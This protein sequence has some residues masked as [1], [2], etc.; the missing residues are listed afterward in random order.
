[1]HTRMRTSTD[2]NL[3]PNLFQDLFH[4]LFQDLF[5]NLFPHLFR[6]LFRC[7]SIILKKFLKT[8]HNNL[9]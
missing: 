7:F 9:H 8:V 4:H 3:F 2:K 6:N 1:M 5:H